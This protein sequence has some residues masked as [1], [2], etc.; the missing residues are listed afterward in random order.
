MTKYYMRKCYRKLFY[1]GKSK[2]VKQKSKLMTFSL[3][4]GIILSLLIVWIFDKNP[5]GLLFQGIKSSFKNELSISRLA[6][7]FVILGLAGISVGVGF[8]TGIFNIGV[9]G[10]MMIG[11]VTAALFAL[12]MGSSV[13]NGIGQ[14]LIILIS[15][16]MGALVGAFS[17]F[18]KV[19]FKIHEVVSTI[20]INWIGFYYLKWIL[21]N[22]NILNSQRTFTKHFNSNF[23]LSINENPMIPVLLI[24]FSV[25][26][27]MWII[28][29]KTNFG[30]KLKMVGQ[31]I[32]AAK[33][34]GI[35][36]KIISISS[37][38]IS[39][40]I[41]G[42]LGAVL[43]FGS[44]NAI[45]VPLADVIPAEGFNGIA[46]SIISF[47]HPLLILPIAFFFSLLKSGIV[48]S[49]A[50]N[51]SMI[52]L[53]L[54]VLMYIASI[55]IIFNKIKFRYWYWKGGKELENIYT[56][57]QLLIEKLDEKYFTLIKKYQKDEKEKVEETANKYLEE[58]SKLKQEFK[59][60]SQSY[61]KDMKI[62][63]EA[64]NA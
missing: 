23:L 50:I 38:G 30:F 17:G 11:G 40:G 27:I 26:I 41:A 45:Q 60:R 25:A 6:T 55:N 63:K 59:I 53:A 22:P 29:Y 33:Y 34:S 35:N 9:S 64:K 37:L 57:N 42:I 2:D 8:K 18:L 12:N 7:N 32:D 4:V 24:L 49:I 10:Q 14:I 39:G 5:F 58:I 19:F 21:T 16:S 13:P 52:S 56:N 47:S 1:S 36:T 43:Y 15:M 3:L 51:T 61:L 31:N 28:I 62:V 44:E 46:I 48:Y 20:L 54:G